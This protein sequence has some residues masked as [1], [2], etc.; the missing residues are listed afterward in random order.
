LCHYTDVI[1]CC[2][3]NRAASCAPRLSP[4][5]KSQL[6]E[7]VAGSYFGSQSRLGKLFTHVHQWLVIV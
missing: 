4:Q 3:I 5:C 6:P 2:V 7:P 1:C